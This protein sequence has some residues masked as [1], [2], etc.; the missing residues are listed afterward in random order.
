MHHKQSDG[1]S[2]SNPDK[3]PQMHE[4]AHHWDKGYMSD[5]EMSHGGFP[6]HHMRGNNYLHLQDEILSRDGKKI[7]HSKRHKIS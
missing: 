1:V 5:K 3:G 7:A 2:K 6:E 4:G